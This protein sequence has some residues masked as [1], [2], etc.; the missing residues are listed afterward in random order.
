MGDPCCVATATPPAAPVATATPPPAPDDAR[1]RARPATPELV[2]PDDPFRDRRLPWAILLKRTWGFSVLV[3]PRC[4]GPRRSDPRRRRTD[5]G[6]AA[7]GAPRRCHRGPRRGR[8]DPHAPEPARSPSPSW[9]PVAP[10]ARARPRASS[11]RLRWHRRT[12]LRRVASPAPALHSA[13]SD[14]GGGTCAATADVGELTVGRRHVDGREARGA[15]ST[16]ERWRGR[17]P[18]TQIK[19]TTL[20]ATVDAGRA[21]GD[22]C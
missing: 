9:T 22:S 2:G 12:R 4:A 20:A 1:R 11:R 7:A 6:P 13:N 15:A 19:T 21:G 5:S 17:Q 8:A 18:E 10:T 3:C 14:E 16:G